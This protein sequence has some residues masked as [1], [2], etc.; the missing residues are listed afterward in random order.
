MELFRSM[1]SSFI[2]ACDV[3]V[4]ERE[5]FPNSIEP[6]DAHFSEHTIENGDKSIAI[7]KRIKCSL[8]KTG[9]S[10]SVLLSF[11]CEWC[12]D[13]MLDLFDDLNGEMD[14]MIWVSFSR[15]EHEHEVLKRAFLFFDFESEKKSETAE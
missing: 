4:T 10:N 1:L 11:S 5:I 6:L 12:R 14:E 7:S 2:K 8:E 9:S 15:K 13:E 3:S